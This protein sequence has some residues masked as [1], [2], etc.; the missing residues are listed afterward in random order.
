M[1][2]S[3]REKSPERCQLLREHPV[4]GGP[5]GLDVDEQCEGFAAGL[6]ESSRGDPSTMA[7]PLPIIPLAS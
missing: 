7:A 5:F 4:R 2:G 6:T 3:A 1:R